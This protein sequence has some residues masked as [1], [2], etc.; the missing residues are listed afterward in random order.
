MKASGASAKA[1]DARRLILASWI[2]RG[3]EIAGTAR[4]V[5]NNAQP[6]AIP[7]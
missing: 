6:S 5:P 1:I 4:N 2:E 7:A 3:I